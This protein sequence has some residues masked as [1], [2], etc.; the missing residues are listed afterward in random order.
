[1]CFLGLSAVVTRQSIVCVLGVLVKCC[2]D[3]R[4]LQQIKIIGSLEKGSVSTGH[5][6]RINVFFELLNVSFQLC[7][8]I[9][10]PEDREKRYKVVG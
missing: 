7:S 3:F 10:K 4:F 6:S 5:L 1:M 8:S 2:N 9:L